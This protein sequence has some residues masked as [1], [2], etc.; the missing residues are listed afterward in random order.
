MRQKRQEAVC[1]LG[2]SEARLAAP[3]L[4]QFRVFTHNLLQ[5]N[6]FFLN[7]QN[8]VGV[9]FDLCEIFL[10]PFDARKN[11]AASRERMRGMYVGACAIRNW[12]CEWITIADVVWFTRLASLTAAAH[13]NAM[14]DNCPQRDIGMSYLKSCILLAT[15]STVVKRYS[16]NFNSKADLM[17]LYVFVFYLFWYLNI[18]AIL[19]LSSGNSGVRI[20]PE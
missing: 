15:G 12:S 16:M 13:D 8:V 18:I 6:S 2:F 1:K 5:R 4:I 20:S 9:E 17:K 19:I 10:S 14:R 11:H 3:R 7:P